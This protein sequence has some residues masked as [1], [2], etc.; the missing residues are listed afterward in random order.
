MSNSKSNPVAT[1][2][3]DETP[4]ES[5]TERALLR[6]HLARSLGEE[7]GDTKVLSHEAAARVFTDKRHEI[8]QALD[9]EPV[10]SKRKLAERL[11]RDPGAVQRDLDHLIEADLV[12]IEQDGRSKRPVLAH[13]TILI[14]PLVAPDS[15][16]P[17]TSYSVENEP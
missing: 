11:G 3:T 17:E 2:P 7:W 1:P 14:E 12:D 5:S 6:T 13:D 10:A 4:D 16:G 9:S 8:L 15:V